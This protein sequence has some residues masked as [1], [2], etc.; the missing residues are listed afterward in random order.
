MRSLRI[1]IYTCFVI[2]IPVFLQAQAGLIDQQLTGKLKLVFAPKGNVNISSPFDQ[3]ELN[4]VIPFNIANVGKTKQLRSTFR[5]AGKTKKGAAVDWSLAGPGEAV[6]DWNATPTKF[7]FD[8]PFIFAANGVRTPLRLHFTSGSGSDA[9][10][11]F[12]GS[13]RKISDTQ[14]DLVLN[15][16]T[17]FVYN[18][19]DLGLENLRQVFVGH[20]TFTGKLNAING[21]KLF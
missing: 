8:L 21:S 4:V 20:V 2:F 1:F 13:A 10:G 15:A 12:S 6:S 3:V 5:W 7:S 17:E 11:G 18:L 16:S 9:F 14:A 19:K